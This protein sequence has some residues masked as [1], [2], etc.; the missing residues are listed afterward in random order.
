MHVQAT[1]DTAMGTAVV[2]RAEAKSQQVTAQ[3]KL[4]ELQAALK[5]TQEDA[6]HQKVS[7]LCLHS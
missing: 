5:S 3:R 1:A 7:L 6:A 4:A 2:L